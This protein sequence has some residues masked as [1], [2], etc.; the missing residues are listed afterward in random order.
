GDATRDLRNIQHALLAFFQEEFVQ[1][2]PEV[3]G[4]CRCGREK[5]LVAFVR[6]VVL[7]DEIANIDPGLPET[8]VE[9]LPLGHLVASDLP[10]SGCHAESL[11]LLRPFRPSIL[12]S[13]WP[14]GDAL[15][16]ARALPLATLCRAFGA[17]FNFKSKR[18]GPRLRR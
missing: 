12:S 18:L 8:Y 2:R 10:S 15:R 11:L 5:Q 6:R 1:L 16:F 9:A 13:K 3:F 14:R 4:A 17:K 7:L